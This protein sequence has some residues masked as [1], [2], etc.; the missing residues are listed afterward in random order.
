MSHTSSVDAIVFT[1]LHALQLALADLSKEG[2]KCSLTKNGTPRAYY[3]NQAGLGLADYVINLPDCAYD[4]G[5]YKD[6]DRKGYVARCDLFANRIGQ[7]LGA[8]AS[9]NEG[10]EQAQLGKLFNRYATHAVTRKA[11]SQGMTVR[12]IP[13]ADGS[14]RLVLGGIAA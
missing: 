14:V 9:G 10:P 3:P 2:V 8:T 7:Y 4:I 5:L 12:R 13:G 1:D 11:V 6:K